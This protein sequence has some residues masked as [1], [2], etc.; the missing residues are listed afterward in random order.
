MS[1]KKDNAKRLPP[2]QRAIERLLKWGKDHPGIT[3]AIPK[4]DLEK[5]EL[6]INGEVETE[7]KVNWKE[8]LKLPLVESISDFHCV[9]GW[10]VLNCRWEGVRFTTIRDLVKPK[11]IARAAT[12]Y[13]A[14]GYTTSLW[15]EELYGVDVILAIKLNGE[16][17]EEGFG[18]P[19]RLVVPGKYAYKS[20]MWVTGIR[21]T[22]DKE[23]GF[24]ELRG[25]S[26][27]ADP[28]TNDRYSS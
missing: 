23:M 1:K 6:T 14:D 8:F 4:I 28:W 11:K 10:S 19:M 26:D 16:P 7:K 15:L 20:A 24:W 12:F 21:F 9:E 25:Y 3:K 27:G 18:R 2:N 22:E 5:W 13:C 17:L